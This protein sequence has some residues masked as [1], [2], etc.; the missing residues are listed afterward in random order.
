MVSLPL[1][2]IDVTSMQLQ[3]IHLLIESTVSS[4]DIRWC[5]AAG[6]TQNLWWVRRYLFKEKIWHHYVSCGNNALYPL[7]EVRTTL[8]L[9]FI[10]ANLSKPQTGVTSLHPC[11]CMFACL[12]GP[13]T[14]SKFLPLYVK[15][16]NHSIVEDMNHGQSGSSIAMTRTETTHGPIQW[17][18]W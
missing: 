5:V 18:E 12:L 15:F 13:T 3:K 17:L 2:L 7:F 16:K 1:T 9:V 4:D 10:G 14:Y 11:M 8:L 6:S